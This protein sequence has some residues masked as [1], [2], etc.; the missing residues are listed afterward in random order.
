MSIRKYPRPRLLGFLLAMPFLLLPASSHA[1]VKTIT[2][3][4]SY[5][6]GDGESPSFAEA[7][8]LQKAKQIALEQAGTYVESYTKIQNYDLTH[9][10]IQTIA[11][12]VLEVEV[13]EKTRALV[14][15]GL[16]FFIKIKA[17]VTTD[18]IQ[19]LAQRIKG[20]NVV[21]EYKKLQEDYARLSKEIEGW[22]QLVSNAPPGPQREVALEQIREREKDFALV[23]RD[24]AAFFKRLV[25]GE[26]LYEKATGQLAK[27]QS[28]V[29]AFSNNLW[30]QGH[31]I[32]VGEP[33]V[34]TNLN[35]PENAEVRVPTRVAANEAMQRTIDETEEFLT[36]VEGFQEM[37]IGRAHV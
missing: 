1:E 4:A 33:S 23:Q 19:D 10:E 11:G 31:I 17:T 20:R 8:V 14:G 37:Q 18:K 15:D 3:E 34:I 30:R 21:E 2:S 25:S 9:E 26:A 35:D 6:M 32:S 28:M 29:V 36:R 24:E 16:K 27:K 5:S 22:K 12:G 7:I 13:L